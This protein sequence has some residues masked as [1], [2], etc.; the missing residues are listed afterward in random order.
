MKTYIKYVIGR[1]VG[2]LK[3]NEFKKGFVRMY[4]F[5]F[6]NFYNKMISALVKVI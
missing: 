4:F 3:C 2:Y 1:Q 6:L 5:F